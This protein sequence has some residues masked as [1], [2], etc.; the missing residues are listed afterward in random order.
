MV[1]AAPELSFDVDV[2]SSDGKW[3]QRGN[4][5]IWCGSRA[6]GEPPYLLHEWTERGVRPF[7]VTGDKP[8]F[9]RVPQGVPYH[10]AHLF[11]FWVVNDT[12]AMVLTAK[13]GDVT[14]T[15]LT[16]GGLTDRPVEATSLFV[17]PKCAARF[18]EEKFTG[19]RAGY[20]RF[21]DA[22]LKRVRAFNADDALRRCPRCGSIHPPIY[23]FDAAADTPDER[24]ARNAG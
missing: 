13:R 10:I 2:T 1:T 16:V 21:I 5:A 24:A 11:G 14:Y 19:L 23:G 3:V 18:G 6:T 4:H 7:R 12:D 9:H 15:M 17:C 20:E 22:A 8:I